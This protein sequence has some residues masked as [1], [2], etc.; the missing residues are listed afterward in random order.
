MVSTRWKRVRRLAIGERDGWRCFYCD[1]ELTWGTL[2]IDHIVPRSQGGSN[3]I[4][5]MVSCCKACNT[6]KS[7]T[8]PAVFLRRKMGLPE[9]K[10]ESFA[11]LLVMV[12][13]PTDTSSGTQ[14]EGPA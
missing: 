5:N 14:D 12:E 4:N 1:E 13:T 7:S 9:W 6:R 10:S 11:A 8:D 3:S 2:T